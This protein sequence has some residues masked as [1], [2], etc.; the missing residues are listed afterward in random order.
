MFHFSVFEMGWSILI[1][2]PHNILFQFVELTE[3][4]SVLVLGT[5][6]SISLSR[7]TA[8]F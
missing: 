1:F 5:F 2:V 6:Y 4:L 3:S 8:L 7:H